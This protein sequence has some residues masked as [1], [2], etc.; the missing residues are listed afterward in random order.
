MEKFSEN[1]VRAALEPYHSKIRGAVVAGFTEWLSLGECRAAKGFGPVLYPRT[2]SNYVFDAI[3]RNAMDTFGSDPT[4]RVIDQ[5]QT[6]KFCF[7]STAVARFKK[8]DDD[9]LGQN[10]QTQAVLEYVDAQQSFPGMPPAAAK[11]EF[12]WTPDILGASVESVLVVARDG[13]H[14]LWS[15]EIEEEVAVSDVIAFPA[16]NG[17]EVDTPLVTPKVKPSKNDAKGN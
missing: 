5:V 14:I 17:P 4:V 11:I 9:N 3:V 12:I 1:E 7:G 8:G 16:P 13:D 10:I 2:V 15:Y 6:A